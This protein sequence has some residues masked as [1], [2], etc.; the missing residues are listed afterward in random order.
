MKKKKK[1]KY[2]RKVRHV[3]E[4]E[5]GGDLPSVGEQTWATLGQQ[6][7]F[8]GGVSSVVSLAKLQLDGLAINSGEIE[9][10]A[11]KYIQYIEQ[12]L[13]WPGKKANAADDVT[14]EVNNISATSFCLPDV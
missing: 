12:K 2:V 1:S 14:C 6:T 10:E 5:V 3:R 13:W 9:K 7:N 4:S 8:P 11:K